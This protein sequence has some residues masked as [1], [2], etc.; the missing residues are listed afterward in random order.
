MAGRRSI[1][2]LR[3]RVASPGLQMPA[4]KSSHSSSSWLSNSASV[5]TDSIPSDWCSDCMDGSRLGGDSQHEE[6]V[7]FLVSRINLP[8]LYRCDSSSAATYFQPKTLS[9]NAQLTSLTVWAPVTSWR[10]TGRCNIVLGSEV[11]GEDDALTDT[12]VATGSAETRYARP[13][14]PV[15]PLLIIWEAKQRCDA[16]PAQRR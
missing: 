1:L 2:R 6:V 5:V 9:Q 7:I 8:T 4:N 3:R 16:H 11:V 12:A 13:W 10:G 15:N 14:R